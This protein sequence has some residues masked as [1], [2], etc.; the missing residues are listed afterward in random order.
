MV[1]AAA[2]ERRSSLREEEVRE[3]C[4]EAWARAYPETGKLDSRGE[5]EE[6]EVAVREAR[7]RTFDLPARKTVWLAYGAVGRV[8]ITHY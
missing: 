2:R 4:V 3:R 6:H 7:R 5:A 8:G 1:N